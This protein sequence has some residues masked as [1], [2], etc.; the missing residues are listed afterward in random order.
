MTTGKDKLKGV[1]D[2]LKSFVDG[3]GYKPKGSSNISALQQGIQYV[4]ESTAQALESI[5]NSCRWYIA[6]QQQDVRAIRT[7]LEERLGNVVSQAISGGSSNQMIT[8]MEQQSGYLRQICDNWASV[9]KTG[10]SQGGRGLK[11]FMN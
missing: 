1:S 8:L 6:Q 3:L 2:M 4:T 11:V 9:M 7:L 5:L 10:H